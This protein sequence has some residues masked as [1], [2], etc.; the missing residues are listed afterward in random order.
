MVEVFKTNVTDQL[1]ANFL[2]DQIHK[3]FIEYEANF[4]LEDCDRIL[5]VESREGLVQSSLVISFLNS[6]GYTLEI[7]PDEINH[8]Q[9]FNKHLQL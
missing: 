9:K 4:D 3:T 1:R 6:L 7:L 2:I 8:W 5:R